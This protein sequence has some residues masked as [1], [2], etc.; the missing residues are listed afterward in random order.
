MYLQTEFSSSLFLDQ[1]EYKVFL[2][3]DDPAWALLSSHLLSTI[4]L[5]FT[6]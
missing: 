4:Q 3:N 5:F 1:P 2:I 6:F